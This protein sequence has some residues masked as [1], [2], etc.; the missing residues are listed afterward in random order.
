MIS[1]HDFLEYFQ[2]VLA[3]EIQMEQTYR[4]M[5]KSLVNSEYIKVFQG[6]MKAEQDH[7][8]KARDIM[9]LFKEGGNEQ[10]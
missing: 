4:Q 6:L 8:A 5:I 3:L 1:N 9:K 2:Q 10:K 7:Q